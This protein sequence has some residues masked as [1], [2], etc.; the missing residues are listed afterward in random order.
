MYHNPLLKSKINAGLRHSYLFFPQFTS[1]KNR[2]TH[3]FL[4]LADINKNRDSATSFKIRT[5]HQ[6]FAKNVYSTTLN[7]QYYFLSE[8]NNNSHTKTQKYKSATHNKLSHNVSANAL[9]FHNTK[10][11]KMLRVQ[12]LP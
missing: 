2:I 3:T 11:K 5:V 1:P 10:E 6:N 7:V 8:N 12:E 4:E 9:I